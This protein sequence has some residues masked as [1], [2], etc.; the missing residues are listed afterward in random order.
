[1]NIDDLRALVSRID[2]NHA[3]KRGGAAYL[4]GFFSAFSA[5]YDQKKWGDVL[6]NKFFVPDQSRY[7]DQAFYESACEL[8]V[9][10]HVR[11]HPVTQFAV[12]KRVNPQSK[13]NVDVWFRVS[14]TE[15]A[16]EVKCPVE[17]Q[18]DRVEGNG[19]QLLLKTAGRIPDHTHQ[20]LDLKKKIEATGA[21]KVAFG[22]NKDLTLKDCLLSANAK[23][24]PTSSVDN[25]NVLFL[26][27]GF[28]GN[29][30]DWYLNLYGHEGLFTDQGFY[31]SSDF[32]LVDVVMLSNLRYWHQHV[33]ERH[34]WTLRDVFL[35]PRIN[36]HGRSSRMSETTRIGLSI[37]DHHLDRFHSFTA[38]TDDPNVPDYVLDALKPGHYVNEGL[39]PAE[40]D[41]YFP[42][43]LYPLGKSAPVPN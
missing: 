43:K 33:A 36:P 14:S 40:R 32:S 6:Q 23:F 8:S 42:V 2:E 26:A 24:S 20:L 39:S 22:K 21:A 27:C 5:V 41:R 37:F 16:V 31:P 12:D 19:M 3:L 18:T 10:N 34:D 38:S 30:G 13:K 29:I 1:M 35:L 25:L 4:D 17:P 28:V 11:K 15:V 7:T 9:A